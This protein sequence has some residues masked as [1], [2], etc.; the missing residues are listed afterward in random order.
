LFIDMEISL[1]EALLGFKK[2]LNHLDNHLVEVASNYNEVIQPFQW[3]VV[4]GEGMPKK[5]YYS[6]FGD[7]HAKMIVNFPKS[8][9]EEQKRLIKMILPD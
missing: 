9:N 2:R 7:L 1:E 4:Q 6:E 3:K 8:L 5:N